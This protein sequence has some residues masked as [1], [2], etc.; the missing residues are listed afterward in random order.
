[1]GVLKRLKNM[2]LRQSFFLLSVVCLLLALG[3]TFGVYQ[4]CNAVSSRYPTGGF[5]IHY[6]GEVTF[7]EEPTPEQ[8]KILELMERIRLTSIVVIP[9]G[10]VGAAGILF[11]RLKLKTPI[12]VLQA[13]TERIRAH[14]LDFTIPEVSSDE[15]GQICAAFETMRGELLKTNREL[16]RQAEERQRLNAAFAHD[17]RNPVTVLKG[18][19]KLLRQDRTDEQALDRLESYANRIE[20]YVEAMSSVQRLEQI[21]VV[22][23]PLPLPQLGKELEETAQLLAPGLETE[24]HFPKDGTAEIDHG[25]F[26]T[27]AENLIGNAARFAKA[28]LIISL[29]TDGEFLRLSVRDDGPGFPGPLLQDGPKPFG[30]LEENATHF[31]MGLY[32]SGLLCIKHGGVLK[33]ENQDGALAQAVFKMG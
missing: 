31:G 20:Q 12:A 3:L 21:P 16:W 8:L 24:L 9:A 25:L 6:N 15:L 32:T 19:V 33:L 30:R 14:D 18:T 5:V 22:K 17:L 13:G 23:K 2:G 27:V 11:Y 4:L 28:K 29:E 7:M 1:M 26:L 10:G